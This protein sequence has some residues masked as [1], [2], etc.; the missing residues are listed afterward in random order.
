MLAFAVWLPRQ[1]PPREEARL[2]TV[3]TS[4]SGLWTVLL[5][6]HE[7]LWELHED[8]IRR[9]VVAHRERLQRISDDTKFE[10]RCPKHEHRHIKDARPRLCDRQ[11]HRLADF[12]HKASRMLVN[13]ALRNRVGRLEYDD[14]DKKWLPTFPWFKLRKLVAEKCEEAGIKFTAVEPSD[15]EE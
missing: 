5:Q 9:L 4:S 13:S 10:R 7:R 12:C 3:R 2:M 1:K 11:D 6:G 15:E 14:R 8:H